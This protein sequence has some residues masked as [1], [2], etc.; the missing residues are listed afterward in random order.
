[1]FLCSSQSMEYLRQRVDILAAGYKHH[2]LNGTTKR[3]NATYLL[4]ALVLAEWHSQSTH[5]WILDRSLYWGKPSVLACSVRSGGK[6]GVKFSVLIP[7]FPLQNNSRIRAAS[8][9]YDDDDDGCVL[10]LFQIFSACHW[11]VMILLGFYTSIG[12]LGMDFFE[13]YISI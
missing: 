8:S 12:L 13:R 5:F 2:H 9:A 1:M 4:S 3:G 11:D 10:C 6:R 7:L